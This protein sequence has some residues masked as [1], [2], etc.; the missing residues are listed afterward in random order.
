MIG[1]VIQAYLCK[2]GLHCEVVKAF[3]ATT[4]VKSTIELLAL[5]GDI[6]SNTEVC[7]LVEGAKAE[8]YTVS[9]F[10]SGS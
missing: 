7:R 1:R 6:Q 4:V 2:L 9:L 10:E 5:T 3:P 8:V